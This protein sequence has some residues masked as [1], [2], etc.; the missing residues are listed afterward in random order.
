MRLAA[1][2]FGWPGLRPAFVFDL[3]A[4][5][6]LEGVVMAFFEGVTARQPAEIASDPE[7]WGE[8]VASELAER[9]LAP[10]DVFLIPSGDLVGQAVNHPDP[11]QREQS[12]K[13]F[14]AFLRFAQ[15]VGSPGV[16]ILPGMVFGG[17]TH[18]TALAR[19]AEALRERVELAQEH[20][21]TLC[22]EPHVASTHPY[23]GAVVD[24]P[25]RVQEL[26]ERVPGL[27]L[28]LDFGH[29]AFQ[30]IPDREIEPLLA[31]AR[32]VHVRGGAR[33]LVQTRFED[34]V[35]DFGRVLDRL[36]EIGFD[37]WVDLEYVHDSRPGCS[38]CDNI[39]EVRKFRDFIRGHEAAR[40]RG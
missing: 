17:E 37:G 38:Q 39:Q 35:I 6:E 34:N 24:T 40:G 33:D 32:H 29:F 21:L 4:E 12:T 14:G 26:V 8:R 22:V 30:G 7:G 1:A 20:Q 36:D 16:T 27:A 23:A 2:D 28:A 13:L 15:R 3:I 11:S 25:E 18:E 5:L 31:W 10:A 9:N 19:A